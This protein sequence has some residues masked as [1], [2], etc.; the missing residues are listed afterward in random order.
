MKTTP[1]NTKAAGTPRLIN[2]T[3]RL[4]VIQEEPSAEQL[5]F[6]TEAINN[7]ASSTSQVLA[8]I[9]EQRTATYQLRHYG[10]NE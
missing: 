4:D 9:L 8:A 5:G 10:I 1:L 6:T 3:T 7:R 2:H